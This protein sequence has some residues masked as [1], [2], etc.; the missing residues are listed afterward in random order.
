MCWMELLINNEVGDSGY[1]A[2][3]D[4]IGNLSLLIYLDLNMGN[5]LQV[6]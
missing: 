5:M 3:G 1:T 4:A 6:G 2:M